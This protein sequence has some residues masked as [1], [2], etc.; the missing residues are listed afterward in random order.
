LTEESVF[1]VCL[2]ALRRAAAQYTGSVY[3]YCFM[4]DHVHLLVGFE[5]GNSVID[6]VRHFKSLSA[7]HYKRLRT[8]RR[9]EGLWQPRFYDRALR[10]EE[11]LEDVAYYIWANP[12]R[13]GLVQDWRRYPLSGSF[14]WDYAALSGSEDPDLREHGQGVRE[15]GNIA[16][17]RNEAGGGAGTPLHR[18]VVVGGGLQT[19]AKK[20][21]T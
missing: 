21:A 4:P 1:E 20:E 16:H 19:P 11:A 9:K 6:F 3:A 10:R 8:T 7:Y 13:A 2:Q 12:G 18:V 17:R 15:V 5:E 14:V